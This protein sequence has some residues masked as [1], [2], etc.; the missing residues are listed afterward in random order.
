MVVNLVLRGLRGSIG[1]RGGVVL[2]LV[3]WIELETG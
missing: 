3:D 1:L 2:V